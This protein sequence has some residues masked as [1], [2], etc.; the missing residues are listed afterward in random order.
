MTPQIDRY[1]VFG[2]PIGHS[3]SPFIH[4]LFARQTNQSLTYTAEC[5]PVG[6]FIE[7]AKA[8]FAD[9]GKGCNVTLPFKEDAYQF[10]S[11]LTERAQLAGAVNTLKK[12]D[13]GEIIGDN[14]D[15]AG[16]VQDLLQH[17][18]VLEGARILI[19]GAGGAARGV[20]KPLLDQKPTSLTITNRTFSKAEELA[21]LFSAYGPVTAK[22]MNTIAEEFDVII[23]ST[24]ASL[25]GELPAISS[26]VFTANSTSY[27]MMY[28]KGDTTF[29]QWAK[30]HGAAH[31]YDGLGMLV[32]QAAESFMLWRG[33]RP[34]AKQILRELRKNLEG[35]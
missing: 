28:G 9:G 24:S 8:F 33:L 6:G 23:N 29:N 4:T 18:V 7:A 19:I 27:D 2:N 3:K 11:R 25:S 26:S 16:L 31:A 14:T 32:G 1:A 21:E 13:D 22:E 10:A 15:G 17:Q 30:Q 12:L 5:A 20:I 35:Q 34:G